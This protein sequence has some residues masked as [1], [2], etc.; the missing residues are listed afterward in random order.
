[1]TAAKCIPLDQVGAEAVGGKAEGLVRA[2]FHILHPGGD[3]ER[4]APV[5]P[6]EFE[7]APLHVED[8]F[9]GEGFISLFEGGLEIPLGP[10]E[11]GYP[12]LPPVL[13]AG[14]DAVVGQG[15]KGVVKYGASVR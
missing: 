5:T 7:F 2:P 11:G 15:T 9:F 6:V 10:V 4:I 3:G 13:L 8:G 12:I 14:H 1:M